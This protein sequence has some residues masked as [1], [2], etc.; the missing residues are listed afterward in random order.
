[1]REWII[2]YIAL[3]AMVVI[4]VYAVILGLNWAHEY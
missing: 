2:V 4:M 3:A 1:M